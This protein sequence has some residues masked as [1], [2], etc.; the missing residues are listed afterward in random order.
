[1]TN[2]VERKTETAPVK[3]VKR[4]QSKPSQQETLEEVAVQ[5]DIA[6]IVEEERAH[7]KDQDLLQ[8]S[9]PQEI[10]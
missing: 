4:K 10:G 5:D 1:M 3:A 8:E 9:A 7:L 2:V 6:E